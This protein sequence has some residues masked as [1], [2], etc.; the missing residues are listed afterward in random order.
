MHNAHRLH[1][2]PT[3]EKTVKYL[4]RVISHSPKL[5]LVRVLDLRLHRER[6]GLGSEFRLTRRNMGA[7]RRC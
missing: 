1:S 2:R 4:E 5:S 3:P 7:G 6:E